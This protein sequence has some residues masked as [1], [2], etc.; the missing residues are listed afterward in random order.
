MSCNLE[1]SKMYNPI[2][3]I[4]KFIES[5]EDTYEPVAKQSWDIPVGHKSKW[6]DKEVPKLI[7]QPVQSF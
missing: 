1:I 3:R 5:V 4:L 2:Y 7:L 6:T